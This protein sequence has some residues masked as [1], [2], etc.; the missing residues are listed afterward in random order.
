MLRSPQAWTID[1]SLT[2]KSEKSKILIDCFLVSKFLGEEGEMRA[3][4]S[5][6]QRAAKVKCPP[7]H[8]MGQEREKDEMPPFPYNGTRAAKG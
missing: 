4:P 1:F 2:R 8:P 6:A 3:F 7:S 5:K